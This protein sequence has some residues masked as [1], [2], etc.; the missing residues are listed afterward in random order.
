MIFPLGREPS[1][2]GPFNLEI[3]FAAFATWLSFYIDFYLSHSYLNLFSSI[4]LNLS[5]SFSFNLIAIFS[6]IL[7]I[8]LSSESVKAASQEYHFLL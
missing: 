2:G 5:S 1:L 4:Y 6:Y 8:I 3:A 7:P